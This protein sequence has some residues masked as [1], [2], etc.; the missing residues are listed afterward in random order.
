MIYKSFADKSLSM[1][2]LGAMRLPQKDGKIDEQH[3][4]KI[5]DIAYKNGIN[6]FDTAYRYHGGQSE[7]FMGKA[8]SR[9][10]R[11]S[12]YLASKMPGHM[13]NYIDG[14]L[15]FQGYLSDLKV[16]D[17]SE[18]FEDQLR[19]CGVEYFDFYLLHN[20]SESS[21][22]FYT[23]DE[24]GVVSYLKK[25]KE[26]GRI[27]HLGL[28][29][30]G[31][32]ETIDKFLSLHDCFEFVQIQLNYLDWTAQDAKAKC[33]VIT[34]HGLPVWVMEPVRGGKLASLGEYTENQMKKLRPEDSIASWAFRFLQS[35]DCV[36][37]VLSG[38]STVEQL[39]DNLRTFEKLNPVNEE[40]KAL[41][42]K[43]GQRLLNTVA[44]TAC[45]YCCEECPENLNIPELI[46][47]YNSSINDES[48]DLKKALLSLSNEESPKK[49]IA[50]GNCKG[51]CPQEI[52]VPEIMAKLSNR[53]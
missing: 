19:R 4:L 41:L 11:E 3:A 1:L 18:V 48:F 40:E 8:L 29:S 21:Y 44:C 32:A 45:R 43:T 50:C 27:R 39:E 9:Y 14:K 10:P 7:P 13:M 46:D 23:N 12:W 2:G 36:S 52:D 51:I 6:Y 47:L 34:K 26:L 20:L 31:S 28:S 22:D 53:I 49:C 37:V 25:Q 24:V 33:E 5:V 38:M 15:G 30:H 16:N 35:L 42:F 17:I